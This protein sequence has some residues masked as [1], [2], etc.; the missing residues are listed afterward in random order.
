MT[1]FN[2]TQSSQK[3][4]NWSILKG[5]RRNSVLW[6]YYDDSTA[7]NVPNSPNY[8][9]QNV[10]FNKT[11][12]LDRSDSNGNRVIGRWN[13]ILNVTVISGASFITSSVNRMNITENCNTLQL[14]LPNGTSEAQNNIQPVDDNS[15]I[16][17][18]MKYSVE[19]YN[20][21]G[22][23]TIT[24]IPSFI[25]NLEDGIKFKSVINCTKEYGN[26]KTFVV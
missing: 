23:S 6:G 17:S 1:V 13:K 19:L 20:S 8:R 14:K 3:L 2:I 15:V 7:T 24:Q 5:S 26:Y 21:R 18:H 9:Q 16:M 4:N 10:T 12:I 22:L 25:A 11:L